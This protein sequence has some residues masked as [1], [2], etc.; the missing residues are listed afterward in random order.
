M[1]K[2]RPI[3]LDEVKKLAGLGLT[4]AEI[5]YNLGF[6]PTYFNERKFKEPEIAEAI[7]AGR[8]KANAFVVSQLMNQVKT[9]NTTA[10][11][12]YLKCRAGW[13]DQPDRL[14]ISGPN[15]GPMA[16][17]ALSAEEREAYV[18]ELDKLLAAHRR[19]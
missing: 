5:S 2:K 9:G 14:E 15:G 10:M 11:I 7:K 13:R 1:A 17:T 4:E 16:V 19:P 8:A 6:S 3:D 12:F 18:T